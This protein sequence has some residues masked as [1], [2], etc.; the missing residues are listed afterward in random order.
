[1]AKRPTPI[2]E[3]IAEGEVLGARKRYEKKRRDDGYVRRA[4]WVHTDDEATVAD[5]VKRLENKRRGTS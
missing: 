5:F 1:M 4:Y 3:Y 2:E